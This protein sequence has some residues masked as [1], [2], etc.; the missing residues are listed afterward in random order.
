[1]KKFV[2]KF[3]YHK[4][5]DEKDYDTVVKKIRAK[6]IRTVFKAIGAFDIGAGRV[7]SLADLVTRCLFNSSPSSLF[8]VQFFN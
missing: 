4:K 5:R 8:R 6:L 1:M 2:N 7:S 3:Q